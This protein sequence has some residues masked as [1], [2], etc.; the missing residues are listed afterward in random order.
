[1][2]LSGL[3]KPTTTL[4]LAD[5]ASTVFPGYGIARNIYISNYK[6]RMI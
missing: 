6:V 5:L 2:I 3:S 1:M 4:V